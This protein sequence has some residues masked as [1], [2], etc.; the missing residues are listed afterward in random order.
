M[1]P[2][3]RRSGLC[4][5]LA[6]A[7]SACAVVPPH[8]S[9]ARLLTPAQS[10]LDAEAR[11]PA[12]TSAWWRGF[13]DPQLDALVE[14]ALAEAPSLALAQARMARAAAAS[15]AAGAS[16][17]ANVGLGLDATRQRFTEHGLYPPPLAGSVRNSATLQAGLSYEFDFFGRHR[18]E[19][20]AALGRERAAAAEAAAARLLLTT[21]LTRSYLALARVLGQAQLLQAQL[22]DRE[23][24]LALVRQRVAAGLDSA[25]ELRGAEAPLPELRRQ[26]LLL[27]EQAELLRHQLAALSAQP[28]AATATLAPA[29]PAAELALGESGALGVDLLGRRPDLVAARWR[30][31]ASVQDVALARSQFYPN[32]SLT[33]F[34]GY[35][36]I[37]LDRLL[38]SGSYQAGFGPSLRL[39][40]FESGRLRAQLRG[41]VAE[42]DAAIAS[43]NQAL[44][45]A[46]R[47]AGDQ[48]SS[49]ASQA[50]Q[51][52]EQEA[53]LRNAQASLE[54]AT[55]RFEAGL[56]TRLAVL[57]A[58][59]QVLQQRRQALEL[60]ARTLD[61]QVS[62][63]RSLG[64][65][66]LT[67]TQR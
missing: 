51:A 61:S 49:L 29:L 50:Q 41:S 34:A 6:A 25:Q 57:N 31:E 13:Q 32:I 28:Q 21:Q 42:Q 39:P 36:A 3:F 53:L 11:L 26:Q 27:N 56:A 35:S 18:A 4:L 40:L 17:S 55:Q 67:P 7:L 2:K 64:G 23:Q 58:R 65:G 30:V 44:L 22:L 12:L 10:G 45:D 37:G 47:D 38:Q 16:A 33:A 66:E 1:K 9:Q 43:Y 15:E 63:L 52:A 24:A 62:L 46:L 14:R 5:L 54:L 20:D 48:L 60:R 59:Q 19:L 8:A